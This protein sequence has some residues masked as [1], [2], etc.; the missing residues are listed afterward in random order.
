MKTQFDLFTQKDSI[1]GLIARGALFVV[2][3]SGGKDSQAMFLKLRD[4][5]PQDQLLVVHA[6]LPG[7]DWNGTWEHVVET[8]KPMVP[9]KT[10]ATKTFMEMVERRGFWP[11]PKYRQCTSDLKRGPIEKTI[12]H[13]LKANPQF[14]GLVV[15]CIG[16][17]ADES[18]NRAK[19]TTFKKSERNS[20]AGREWYEWLPIFD[21]SIDDVWTAILM[22]GQTAHWAYGEGMSRL[23]CM[24]CIMASKEDLTISARLNPK[25]Y[26]EHVAMEKKIDQTFAMPVK[27]ERKFL[28]EITGIQAIAA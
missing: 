8:V 26:A 24:F 10:T 19:L 16:I 23:S 22:A 27:G 12:R 7:A 13:Y 6:D 28:E 21:Y 20:K 3:H 14:D 18:A 4:M 11:S 9:I 2:N 1:E 17:R 25:A 15:N 5:V